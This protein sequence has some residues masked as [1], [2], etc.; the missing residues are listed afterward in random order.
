MAGT[1]IVAGASIYATTAVQ[2]GTDVKANGAVQ[3]GASVNGGFV[4][5]TLYNTG[6]QQI[7]YDSLAPNADVYIN[8][9]LGN[10]FEVDI[11]LHNMTG[12]IFCYL[13]DPANPLHPVA[14]NGGQFIT[15]LFVNS[16]ANTPSVVFQYESTGGFH[17]AGIMKLNAS[18]AQTITFAF[19]GTAAYEVSRVQGLSL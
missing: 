19:N 4:M 13:R 1:T 18:S 6:F 12:T 5:P 7:A 8:P 11:V 10:V 3:A 15:I 2:A 14:L 9:N 16:T 17:T